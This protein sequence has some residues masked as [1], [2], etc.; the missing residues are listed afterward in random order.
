[1]LPGLCTESYESYAE[2]MSEPAAEM[3]IS[4]ARDQFA[5]VV[6]RAAY[7][8]VVTYVTRRG[9]RLAAVVPAARLA[10]DA[11]RAREAATAQTC[12][13]L[14]ASVAGADAATRA[15]VRAVIEELLAAAE[16]AVDVAAA[17][18]AWVE[19]EAGAPTV[20]LAQLRAE[21]GS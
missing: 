11:A 21:L 16:D 2:A 6:N 7:A 14:W 4:D 20:S 15:G 3:P 19:V 10:A 9:R 8:G 1:M 5:E 12:R 13:Q 17:D 18:A